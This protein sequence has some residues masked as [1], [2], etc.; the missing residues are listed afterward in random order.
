MIERLTVRTFKSLDDVRVEL[1][2]VN[3]FI[4]ANGSNN[5]DWDKRS[6]RICRDVLGL[7]DWARS[8]GA[9]SAP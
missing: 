2:L 7:V 5:A 1:G 8:F 4:G 9:T 3:V 6:R